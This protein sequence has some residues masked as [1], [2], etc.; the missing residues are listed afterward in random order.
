[1]N[2]ILPTVLI[3]FV[4]SGNQTGHIAGRTKELSRVNR[5][6]HAE[7]CDK[8]YYLEDPRPD[9]LRHF[10]PSLR[11]IFWAIPVYKNANTTVLSTPSR[12]F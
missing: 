8:P 12:N 4:H 10:L 9:G 6:E 2:R 5:T 11:E 7:E 3:S 1:M